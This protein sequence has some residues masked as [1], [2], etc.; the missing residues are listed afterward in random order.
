[1]RV[2]LTRQASADLGIHA[3]EYAGSI[4]QAD[5]PL[6]ARVLGVTVLASGAVAAAASLSL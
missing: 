3:Y 1:M 5:K 2:I 6:L 4:L